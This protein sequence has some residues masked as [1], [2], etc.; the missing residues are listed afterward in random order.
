MESR[1]VVTMSSVSPGAISR[2]IAAVLLLGLCACAADA[3]AVKRV[4]PACSTRGPE[5]APVFYVG[6]AQTVLSE[7]ARVARD[8]SLATGTAKGE[9]YVVFAPAG[10]VSE[11]KLALSDELSPGDVECVANAFLA[12]RVDAFTGNQV[13]VRKA[14]HSAE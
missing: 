8:C 2:P 13:T 10:C 11:V 14:L 5:R 7:S 4:N 1:A 12:A 3:V 9:A 6:D